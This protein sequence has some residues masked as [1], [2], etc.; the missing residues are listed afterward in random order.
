LDLIKDKFGNYVIQRVI[1]VSEEES[2]KSMIEKVL[3]LGTLLKKNK[4][5]ARHVFTYLEKQHGIF[6]N[7]GDE[8]EKKGA[9]KGERKRI[10]LKNQY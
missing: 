2:K 3:H 10:V 4:S 9:K 6:L 1:E 7:K 8:G 5:H